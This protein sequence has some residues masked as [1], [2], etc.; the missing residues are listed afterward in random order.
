MAALSANEASRET[1]IAMFISSLKNQTPPK[2]KEVLFEIHLI[3]NIS[4]NH[5]DG[6]VIASSDSF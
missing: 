1:S 2:N 4:N 6:K 3:Q 5:Y